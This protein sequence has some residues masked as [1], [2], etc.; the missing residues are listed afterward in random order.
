MSEVCVRCQSSGEDRR[1]L[2]MAC[3]YAMEELKMP[4]L[5]QVSIHGKFCKKIEDSPSPF[6]PIP[7]FGPPDPDSEPDHH[8]FYTLR[9]CKRC[10]SEWLAAIKK[11]FN[12]PPQGRDGD[13]DVRQP[14]TV[15]TGIFIRDFGNTKEITQEEW[16]E[17]QR[18]AVEKHR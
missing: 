17:R 5:E 13:A 10:R 1:T 8:R 3:F 15:G 6:G 2:W 9:V 18:K 16:D 12:S 7:V 4:G 11:W 14:S